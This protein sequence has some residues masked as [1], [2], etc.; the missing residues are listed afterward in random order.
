MSRRIAW[1]SPRRASHHHLAQVRVRSSGVG[2]QREE[3][4]AFPGML[5][6]RFYCSVMNLIVHPAGL[7]VPRGVDLSHL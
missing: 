6:V 4:M 5:F 2:K 7:A 1:D 3:Q